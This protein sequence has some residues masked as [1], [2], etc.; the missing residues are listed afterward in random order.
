MAEQTSVMI[1][2]VDGGDI[3]GYGHVMRSTGI[4]E[5]LKT[6]GMTPVFY[7]REVDG[8]GVAM[9]KRNGWD[10]VMIPEEI[11]VND[12]PAWVLEHC[13]TEHASPRLVFIDGYHIPDAHRVLY[14]EQAPVMVSDVFG[15]RDYSA[16]S[17]V[18]NAYADAPDLDYSLRGPHTE[19][20][21]G[22]R[23]AVL[24]RQVRQRV[25]ETVEEQ[26]SFLRRVV[27]NGG[28]VDEHDVTGR[29][30]SALAALPPQETPEQMLFVTGEMY[31]FG[32][33]LNGRLRALPFA[34]RVVQPP[35][36]L[37]LVRKAD[38]VLMAGGSTQYEA[39]AMGTPYICL[40]VEEN[41]LG[42]AR[43]ME[44][45]DCT[46]VAGWLNDLSDADIL[47]AYQAIA[48]D[49]GQRTARARKARDLVDGQGAKRVVQALLAH[50][51]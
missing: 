1:L 22:P 46:R 18:Y 2:R 50:E 49:P 41:Q 3:I 32:E 13:I 20:L 11:R 6:A 45:L 16:C 10:P 28:G 39:A 7:T 34:H 5:A 30:A 44:R 37:N 19:L 48:A 25:V 12:E 21:L 23:Y 38:L 17:L 40:P 15:G 24:R 4:A 51:S 36:W 8:S 27:V 14:S 35:N 29:V 26:P 43:A 42:F 47:H 33:R 31:P 9:L